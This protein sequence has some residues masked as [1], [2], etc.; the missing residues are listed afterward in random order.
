PQL[1]SVLENSAVAPSGL[2]HCT[3]VPTADA[4]RF[5]LPPLCGFTSPASLHF[6]FRNRV[7]RTLSRIDFNMGSDSPRRT[8][9]ELGVLR[10]LCRVTEKKS[11]LFVG[12]P[13]RSR[14]GGIEPAASAAG[15]CA[16]MNRAS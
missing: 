11:R 5:N 2:I 15:V 4:V 7:A 14:G 16:W 9:G 10:Y 3:L 1:P 12:L 8:A 13:A 6:E